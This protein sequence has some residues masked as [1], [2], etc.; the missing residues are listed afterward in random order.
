MT[1]QVTGEIATL[2]ATPERTLG[3]GLVRQTRGFLRYLV[4]R[5]KPALVGLIYLVLN[6]IMATVPGLIAPYSPTEADPSSIL[7]APNSSHWFGTDSHGMDVL[8]RIVWAPRI[9]LVVGLSAVLCSFIGGVFVGVWVGF[10]DGRRSA[11]GWVSEGGM[12]VIDIL[13]A[14]PIFVLALALM[15]VA[16][17]SILNVLLVLIVLQTPIFIR[18][19]RSA[20]LELRSRPFLEAA[21]C[22]GNGDLR[23]VMRHVLPNSLSPPLVNASVLAGSA[24]LITSGLS[25]IGAGVPAP[26]PE[27]GYMIATGAPSLVLGAW[28]PAMFPGIALA[29]TVL[30]FALVGDALRQFLYP[31]SGR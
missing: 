13:Q 23:L 3:G 20:V 31:V 11:R 28:W 15:A 7:V 2:S 26:T 12:R 27:W 1:D 5:D 4:Q 9:D 16:G 29:L 17:R 30:S 14:F 18:L 22:S 10:Y 19:T 21:R 6:L 25:F 24:I 8:S